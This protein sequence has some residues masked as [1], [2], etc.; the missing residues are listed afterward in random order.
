MSVPEGRIIS[1]PA[2]YDCF[3]DRPEIEPNSDISGLGI[4]AGFLG[5][6]YLAV[7][8]ITAHF[9]LAYDPNKRPD[10]G[11]VTSDQDCETQQLQPSRVQN[12]RRSV[13]SSTNAINNLHSEGPIQRRNEDYPPSS[14]QFGSLALQEG[15]TTPRGGQDLLDHQ[16]Q[17]I[18]EAECDKKWSPN[19]IDQLIFGNEFGRWLFPKRSSLQDPDPF[20]RDMRKA[21][22][23]Y[24]LAFCD[25]QSIT[26]LAILLSAFAM[27]GGPSG[28]S[29]Y[30]WQIA[31]LLAWLANITHLVG[32]TFLQG[33]L[34][35]RPLHR[36]VRLVPTTILLILLLVA[37]FPTGWFNWSYLDRHWG[38]N[39][40]S[41][42]SYARCFFN[43][44]TAT[45][46]ALDSSDMRVGFPEGS[47]SSMI[48]SMLFLS[49]SFGI[50]LIKLSRRA[51]NFFRNVVRRSARRRLRQLA[52]DTMARF[53]TASPRLNFV[54]QY[55]FV[56][57]LIAILMTARIYTDVATSTFSEVLFAWVAVLW[58]TIRIFATRASVHLDENDFTFGQIVAVLLLIG[59]TITAALTAWPLLPRRRTP[60]DCRRT[61]LAPFSWL[62]EGIVA[63]AT[64]FST[65][66]Y[67][68]DA[69]EPINHVMCHHK[70]PLQLAN[71][72]MSYQ[73][74]WT[75][76]IVFIVVV[77]LVGCS[78]ASIRHTTLFMEHTPNGLGF[79]QCR[80]K[81]LL[82]V[83]QMESRTTCQLSDDEI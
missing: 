34:R 70:K 64:S 11:I 43:V 39:P 56:N 74:P 23:H 18:C 37:L 72:S 79:L 48:F 2:I 63:W 54:R 60:Q 76:V 53:E 69:N 7:V 75:D 61:R 73:A 49:T 36:N 10:H 30:H 31:V 38:A 4:L 25:G 27:L 1:Q 77:N 22:D 45:Q 20:A 80:E 12:L 44:Q 5:T 82:A 40:A 52:L 50:R 33:Y 9:F 46:R 32:L 24:I 78:I 55:F 6:A 14:S 28:I 51:S 8:I 13:T 19:P 29:A 62:K 47:G 58:V 35:Q 83:I 16:T 15:V 26:G 21:F 59:P 17:C 68:F 3:K 67:R 57:F 81:T 65:P 41:P 71:K 42:S 66:Q